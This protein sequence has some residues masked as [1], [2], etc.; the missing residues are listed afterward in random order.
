MFLFF[1]TSVLCE[2]F[3]FT[4]PEESLN[5]AFT[6]DPENINQGFFKPDATTNLRF[7]VKI[8]SKDKRKIFYINDSLEEAVETHFSFNNTESQDVD[9]SITSFKVDQA[10]PV[11]PCE[12]QMKF[13]SSADTFNNKV[14]KEV[15][16]KPA[17]NALNT[18]L[19]KLSQITTATKVVYNKSGDLNYEQRRLSEFVVLFSILSLLIF[20]FFNFFQLYLMK[21]YLNQKKYL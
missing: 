3:L 7:K 9:L 2:I 8:I 10:I 20:S 1:L 17:I 14:S 19:E 12:F 13:E 16:Y 4:N 6:L 11:S 18:L 21:S 5:I 15:Q